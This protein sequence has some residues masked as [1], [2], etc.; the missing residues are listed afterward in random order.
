LELITTARAAAFT[1]QLPAYRAAPSVYR[2]RLYAQTFPR[3]VAGARKYILVSTNTDHVITFDLQH[4]ATDDMIRQ[5][6]EAI[7]QSAK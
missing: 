7:N 2:Q 4:N 6:A 3:A 1:N 5:Q